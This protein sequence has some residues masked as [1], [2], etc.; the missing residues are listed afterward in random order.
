VV[1][2]EETS[3][4]PGNGSG[5]EVVVITNARPCRIVEW[6][7]GNLIRRKGWG[8]T[9]SSNDGWYNTELTSLVQTRDTIYL[10]LRNDF[11]SCPGLSCFLL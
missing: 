4:Q 3:R 7:V 1:D 5:V 6:P 8:S 10:Q 9:G 2:L 11:G